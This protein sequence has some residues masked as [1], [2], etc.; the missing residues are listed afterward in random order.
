MVCCV[1]LWDIA[2]PVWAQFFTL[3]FCPPSGI[4]FFIRKA[5]SGWLKRK[6][7]DWPKHSIQ[8]AHKPKQLLWSWEW[9]CITLYIKHMPE[10][11]IS[12]DLGSFRPVLY[13]SVRGTEGGKEYLPSFYMNK[14]EHLTLW[15]RIRL[16]ACWVRGKIDKPNSGSVES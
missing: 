8:P 7:A 2:L 11:S 15:F 10:E 5:S 13:R 1:L 3:A 16:L 4:M 6:N 14:Q 9:K 12:N